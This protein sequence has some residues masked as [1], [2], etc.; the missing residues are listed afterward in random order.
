[1]SMAMLTVTEILILLALMNSSDSELFIATQARI[2]A[3]QLCPSMIEAIRLGRGDI[4][5]LP[6]LPELLGFFLIVFSS[7]VRFWCFKALGHMFS[8]K[9][10]LVKDHRLITSGPYAYARHPGYGAFYIMVL[11]AFILHVSILRDTGIQLHPWIFG[12]Q[13]E[14]LYCDWIIATFTIW[15]VITAYS[16]TTVSRRVAI[17]DELLEKTFGDEWRSWREKTPYALIP[18]TI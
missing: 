11:G 10:A 7:L 4:S 15:F 17:E 1:M 5:S 3:S 14:P 13:S 8:Y 9:I 2:F 18:G 12:N 16:L 6:P